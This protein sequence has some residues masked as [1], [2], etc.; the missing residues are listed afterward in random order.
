MI[1]QTGSEVELMNKDLVL[2][3]DSRELPN[4][5][6]FS[7]ERQRGESYQR[8]TNGNAS[9]GSTTTTNSNTDEEVS[10]FRQL[11]PNYFLQQ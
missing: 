2:R 7:T 8:I 3:S 1:K 6:L 4:N 9:N 11:D 10:V 5:R